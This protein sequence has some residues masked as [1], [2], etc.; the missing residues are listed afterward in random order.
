V[1]AAMKFYQRALDY[2]YTAERFAASV[3]AQDPLGT[4]AKKDGL[5]REFVDELSPF[6]RKQLERAFIYYDRM[7]TVRGQER[8]IFPSERGGEAAEKNF[9]AAP[10]FKHVQGLMDAHETRTEE[11]A[12]RRAEQA[13]RRSLA[14]ARR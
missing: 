8:S 4:L 14:P 3:R 7:N 13:E 1:Q 10:R 12:R 11:E 5:R 2:G 9:R 6:D